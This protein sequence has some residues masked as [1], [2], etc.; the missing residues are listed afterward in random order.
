MVEI[1]HRGEANCKI[2]RE[3]SAPAYAERLF[4]GES[5]RPI[6]S[7]ES[8]NRR[9]TMPKRPPLPRDTQRQSTII[10]LAAQ[11]KLNFC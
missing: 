5:C 8:L 6:N 10:S 2:T 9:S 11:R 3:L 4:G 7:R 1:A